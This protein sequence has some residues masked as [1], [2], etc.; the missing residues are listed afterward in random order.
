MLRFLVLYFLKKIFD[1]LEIKNFWLWALVFG[2]SL[3]STTLVIFQ[4]MYA[5]MSMFM[6]I[7]TYFAIKIINNDFEFDKSN[8]RKLLWTIV[9]GGLSH[10]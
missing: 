9:L 8:H 7:Y 4:R 10:Y 6:V 2:V 1:Y 3:G 5:L